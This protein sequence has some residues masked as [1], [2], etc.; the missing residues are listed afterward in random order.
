MRLRGWESWFAE[1][2]VQSQDVRN[3]IKL[4]GSTQTIVMK[5][6]IGG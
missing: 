4:I 1:L 6:L 3:F 2:S 5:S